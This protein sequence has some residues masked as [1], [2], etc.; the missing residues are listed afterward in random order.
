[1]IQQMVQGSPMVEHNPCLASIL[2][3]IRSP[4]WGS[5]SSSESESTGGPSKSL[6][7]RWWHSARQLCRWQ[8]MP[9]STNS[10]PSVCQACNLA[11]QRR[12]IEDASN[13]Q[14][15]LSAHLRAL[16]SDWFQNH[17]FF[18]GTW[19]P[20]PTW[21]KSRKTLLKCDSTNFSARSSNAMSSSF[22][23]ALLRDVFSTSSTGG[24]L[25]SN[26]N[27]STGWTSKSALEI[28]QQLLAKVWPHG[29]ILGQNQRREKNTEAGNCNKR[30][31]GT[32]HL[33]LHTRHLSHEFLVSCE[34]VNK[35]R[36]SPH[37]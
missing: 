32:V 31:C 10:V 35:I 26:S 37:M 17:A 18:F 3:L 25:S 20:G 8:V 34:K 7:R 11:A 1:M 23:A 13:K 19:P 16:S 9:K 24:P 12:R 33:D 6:S 29:N 15:L 36:L 4:P 28:S 30:S 14:R 2:W 21:R 5:E 22:S 27:S